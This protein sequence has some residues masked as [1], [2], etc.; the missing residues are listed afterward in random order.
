[1]VIVTSFM[2]LRMSL[3]NLFLLFGKL[4]IKMFAISLV[5][6]VIF[7]VAYFTILITDIN[8]IKPENLSELNKYNSHF[9]TL[10]F[11]RYSNNFELIWDLIMLSGRSFLA[12]SIEVSGIYGFL[13][14]IEG[15]LGLT[16]PA[17]FFSLA[18][19][20]AIS[21]D[22]NLKLI[23]IKLS[24]GEKL[25]YLTDIL[26]EDEK[27][28]EVMSYFKIG[29]KN[30]FVYKKNEVEIYLLEQDGHIKNYKIKL[31]D[32]EY[33]LY[34]KFKVDWKNIDLDFLDKTHY[35][36]GFSKYMGLS[37]KDSLEHNLSHLKGS[38]D[39]E[40][41][42]TISFKLRYKLSNVT[43][44]QDLE[45]Y[46]SE[47]Y[48]VISEIR[49]IGIVSSIFE[50]VNKINEIHEKEIRDKKNEEEALSREKIREAQKNKRKY[51]KIKY[52]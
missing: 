23:E 33:K 44:T 17:I 43:A 6:I 24:N 18:I 48:N 36:L 7:T 52:L 10:D 39:F 29:I 20:K 12:G 28:E 21:D 37:I 34:E 47:F 50:E 19:S 51:R 5:L 8:S 16:Y 42:E 40:R 4:L 46:K 27:S 38:H 49:S 41:L 15:Y 32:E 13:S 2:T 22:K 1:M 14:I 25:V 30:F 3:G 11:N 26:N 35:F 31:T 9:P 45:N